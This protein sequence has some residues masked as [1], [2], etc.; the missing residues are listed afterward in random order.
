MVHIKRR[1]VISFFILCLFCIFSITAY[2]A[3][4]VIPRTS[5]DYKGTDVVASASTPYR[6]EK[7]YFKDEAE[8]LTKAQE[9]SIWERIQAAADTMDIKIAFF[10]G[11]NYRTDPE[12]E[13]FT[14]NCASAVFG[15]NSDSLFIYIDFEGYSPAYDYVRALNK[16]QNVFTETA[17]NKILQ[18]M[19]QSLP[20]SSEPVYSDNVN[21]ALLQGIDEVS[22]QYRSG[23]A[24]APSTV[25]NTARQQQPPPQASEEQGFLGISTTMW[26]GIG[27]F[28]AVVVV[29][30]F[31]SR[32][33]R[34]I[35]PRRSSGSYYNGGSSYYGDN[36]YYRRSGTYYGSYH[37]SRPPRRPP[38]PPHHSSPPRSSPPRSSPPSSRPS[39]PSSSG[40]GHHR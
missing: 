36:N 4:P 30:S 9:K 15:V 14:Y 19:Y 1:I 23:N 37:H 35:V 33:F 17:R 22:I 5:F 8:V 31:I 16:A 27:I 18:A 29:I 6:S 28:I 13:A 3:D 2:A 40:S 21:R 20:Q 11:G 26:I 7:A 25:S 38:P 39:G 12:T 24:P 10:I 32:L 34:R